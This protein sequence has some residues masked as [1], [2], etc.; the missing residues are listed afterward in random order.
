M[1]QR[2]RS[3]A[4][5]HTTADR[6]ESDNRAHPSPGIVGLLINPSELFKNK[7][8]DFRPIY[9]PD[10]AASNRFGRL[11]VPR[12]RIDRAMKLLLIAH[13]ESPFTVHFASK[14][15]ELGHQVT[16]L[17]TRE[18]LGD[19]VEYS[20]GVSHVPFARGLSGLFRRLW[21]NKLHGYHPSSSPQWHPMNILTLLRH[22]YL[23]MFINRVLSRIE[24]DAV[25][26]HNLAVGGFFAALIKRDVTKVC[27]T[28]GVDISTHEFSPFYFVNHPLIV[29]K[30]VKALD[31]VLTGDEEVYRP[32]FEEKQ[33]AN[34]ANVVYL[35][36][37][38][39]E[40]DRFSPSYR[41]P[42]LRREYF[43]VEEQTPLAICQR[44]PRPNVLDFPGIIRAVHRVVEKQEDFVFAVFTGGTDV[45]D[46]KAL[47]EQLGIAA[48]IRFIENVPYDDLHLY[49]A[50]GDIF[51][52]PANVKQVPKIAG[53][54]ISGSILESMSCGLV[55]VVSARPSI[56][57]VLPPEARPFVFEDFE[58]DLPDTLRRA[59]HARH[60]REIKTAV[61]NAVTEKANW[62]RNIKLTESLLQ[63]GGRH[64]SRVASDI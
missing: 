33:L 14:F 47:V 41:D 27:S 1:A 39:V 5:G 28:L 58:S 48:H 34:L 44:P 3:E 35:G 57:W 32:I 11:W 13:S 61:R 19:L 49:V 62:A 18:F 38:G 59:I 40:V 46:L 56:D 52:D 60:S 24:F 53:M 45:S 21:G 6:L 37:W 31:H 29:R 30:A 42:D 64:A 54:G 20:N 51:I 7:R 9:V 63:A 23:T 36:H 55:P 26:A 17:S 43:R 25:F 15:Q 8:T 4:T 2:R 16:V 10:S 12:P 50:Q 22:I